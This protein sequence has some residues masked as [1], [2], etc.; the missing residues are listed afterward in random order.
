MFCHAGV[1][2]HHYNENFNDGARDKP[3]AASQDA[4]GAVTKTYQSHELRF[5]PCKTP[6]SVFADNFM[7]LISEIC[8]RCVAAETNCCRIYRVGQNSQHHIWD[9]MF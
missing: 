6:D 3:S 2:I 5:S 9:A 4:G 1:R 7:L 8:S